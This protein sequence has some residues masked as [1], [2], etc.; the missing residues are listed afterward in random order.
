MSPRCGCAC[1]VLATHAPALPNLSLTGA[2]LSHSP[3]FVIGGGQVYKE[4]IRMREC[5]RILLTRV[6][7]PPFADCD[8]FFPAIDPAL[9][10][11]SG[12]FSLFH[13]VVVLLS[14]LFCCFF[15]GLASHVLGMLVCLSASRF[16]SL[17]TRVL[18][19]L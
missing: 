18:C 15:F 7:S 12:F 3:V 17:L 10:Q 5:Q 6:L 16:R 1:L 11:V 19:G 2:L 9:F 14:S 4:A 13:A 8:T